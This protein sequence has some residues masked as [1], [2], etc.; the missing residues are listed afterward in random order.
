MLIRT[1][2]EIN[3]V[4][5]GNGVSRRFLIK[6]DDIGYTLTDTLVRAGTESLLHYPHHLEAC[7][8]ISGTGWVSDT[9]GDSYRIE[10]GMLY[11]LD[12][13][14]P[15]T[16]AADADGDLRLVCVFAPALEGTETHALQ[17]DGYSRYERAAAPDGPKP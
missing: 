6:S 5:W 13:H 7:Y 3:T 1:E 10:P 14:D 12:K 17:T 9:S 15:H 16:L 11:A 2:Y 8:C 4:D